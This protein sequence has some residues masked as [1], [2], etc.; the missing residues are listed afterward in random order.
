VLGFSDRL[1]R[2][3][4]VHQSNGRTEP[5]SR[6]WNRIYGTFVLDRG[7]LVLFLKPWYRLPESSDTNPDIDDYM[8]YGEFLAVY[9]WHGRTLSL[10]LR[11]NLRSS[12]N[13]G[14][15]EINYTHPINKYVK[16]LVQFFNGYGE[17]LLDYNHPSNRISVGFSLS[18]WL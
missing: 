4:A 9:P 3:G 7:R 16:A 17:C 2:I 8:G 11:N 12:G 10:M 18:D 14:A 1:V 5:L 15:I 13:K 6:S